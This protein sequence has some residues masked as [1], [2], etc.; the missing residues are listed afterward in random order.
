MTCA[1]S[2]TLNAMPEPLTRVSPS[3]A[4]GHVTRLRFRGRFFKGLAALYLIFGAGA[5]VLTWAS[6]LLFGVISYQT[7]AFA[8]LAGAGLMG[9]AAHASLAVTNP[10]ALRL[11]TF[12]MSG[13]LMPTALTWD[14][15]ASVG[16]VGRRSGRAIGI[17]LHD[18]KACFW[19]MSMWQR[20]IRAGAPKPW[21][22]VLRTDELSMD[23]ADL[24][25]LI[26][27]YRKLHQS[28]D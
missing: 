21:H 9:A 27:T 4:T 19:R 2:H 22:L 28:L 26:D 16:S 24:L 13:W 12:G 3:A 6:F 10:T 5:V 14:E 7:A 11:D 25:V 1:D 20:L 18:R 15:V 23:H 8:M 17:R